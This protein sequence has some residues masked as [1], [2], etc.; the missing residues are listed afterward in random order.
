MHLNTTCTGLSN[1]VINDNKEQGGR[2]ALFCDDFVESNRKTELLDTEQYRCTQSV[3]TRVET[4]FEKYGSRIQEVINTVIE[5]KV[6]ASL[7]KT[8]SMEKSEK[9]HKVSSSF[10]V[11]GL[12]EELTKSKKETLS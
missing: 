2:V 8:D 4:D 11:R 6:N 9:N 10:R 7:E 5:P 12:P 1:V 3:E